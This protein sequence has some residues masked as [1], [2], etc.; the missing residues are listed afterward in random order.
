M[1][2]DAVKIVATLF[3]L[4]V[5]VGVLTMALNRPANANALMAAG[6]GSISGVTSALEG[7]VKG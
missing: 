4:A 3:T 2:A 5:L 1:E 7:G 6:A